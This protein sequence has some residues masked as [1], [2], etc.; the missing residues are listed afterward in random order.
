MT[1]A[2]LHYRLI[3]LPNASYLI[4]SLDDYALRHFFCQLKILIY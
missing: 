1:K 4:S 2:I 3:N